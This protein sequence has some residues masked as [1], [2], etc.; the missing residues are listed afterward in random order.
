MAADLLTAAWLCEQLAGAT[1][2]L[3]YNQIL[4]CTSALVIAQQESIDAKVDL[5][6]R[7]HYLAG[8][9]H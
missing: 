5:L 6:I 3:L 2:S 1:F 9:S 7:K 8:K 4:A